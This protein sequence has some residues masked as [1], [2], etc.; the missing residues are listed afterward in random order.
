LRKERPFI[1]RAGVNARVSPPRDQH[2]LERAAPHESLNGL[3]P[4]DVYFGRAETILVNGES[5]AANLTERGFKWFF[6]TTPIA[7]DFAKVF[8]EFLTYKRGSTSRSTSPT[9]RTRPMV[10][11][12]L[13]RP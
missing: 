3:T 9:R 1:G 12:S 2:L 4:A 7:S 13:T 5:V 11:L 8:S 6:R 10:A